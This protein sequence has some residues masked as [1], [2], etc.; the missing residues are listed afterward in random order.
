MRDLIEQQMLYLTILYQQQQNEV[1]SKDVQ[2]ISSADD[3]KSKSLESSRKISS[4]N[5]SS[6]KTRAELRSQDLRKDNKYTYARSSDKYRHRDRRRSRSRGRS[7]SRDRRY[8]D[9][10]DHHRRDV[11][12]ISNVTVYE[13]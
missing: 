7:R 10:R 9:E 8:R 3:F 6:E 2:P 1:T 11:G 12:E 5:S 4:R 13:D